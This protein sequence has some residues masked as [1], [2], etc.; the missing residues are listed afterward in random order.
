MTNSEFRV[1]VTA[2]ITALQA[3]LKGVQAELDKFK[4]SADG[5][6]DA[7][8]AVEANANRGRLVAFAFGQVLRD[9]GFF[10]QDFRLGILAISNNIPILIDQL[11]LLSG[12]SKAVGGALSLLGSLLTAGLTIWAYSGDAVKKNKQSI[13]DWRKSLDD[14]I[15][16]QLR[17]RQA[18][19]E[20]STSL[21]ILYRAATNAA[22]SNKTRTQAAK[23]LQN[24]YPQIFGNL[25]TEAIKLGK[26]KTAYDELKKSIIEAATAEAA[27]N[28][29]VENVSR[30]LDNEE[31][32]REAR[33]KRIKAEN[34][35][36]K[37]QQKTKGVNEDLFAA[38]MAQGVPGASV[39]VNNDISK[40]L[41]R[42]AQLKLEIAGYDKT[43]YS[44]TSDTNTLNERNNQLL[45]EIDK[46]AKSYVDSLSMGDLAPLEKSTE[47]VDER[48]KAIIEALNTYQSK[49]SDIQKTPAITPFDIKKQSVEALGDLIV[50]LEKIEGTQDTVAKLTQKFNELNLAITKFPFSL[51]LFEMVPQM[52]K[53]FTD[54][55][56]RE[57]ERFRQQVDESIVGAISN[58]LAGMGQAIANGTN[59]AKGALGGF[60]NAMS[61][62]LQQVGEGIIRTAI[63]TGKLAIFIGK[64][65]AGIQKAL[66]TMNP[67]LAIGAGVALLALA[68]AAR[69]G[70][71]NIARG[72]NADTGGGASSTPV[73]S[74]FGSV[75]GATAFP[76][77][78][79]SMAINSALSRNATLE[80][81]VS[82][83]DLV[84]LM[85]RATNNR[86]EYF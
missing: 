16:V 36:L 84:I 81:R 59:V 14:A 85:N 23:E 27:K 52:I 42:Q 19:L 9:A 60:L 8:K 50:S 47:V 61:G 86:N 17:G 49:L 33:I 62:I 56:M 65:I 10:A 13:D 28:K 18:A 77:S 73:G 55:S 40:S 48:M 82:G 44:A 58:S 21:D 41:A 67:L 43:I 37:E 3:S 2:D 12:V 80:T 74:S 24:L 39:K 15:E 66:A 34:E 69:G 35:L 45:Q 83:N 79:S 38:S 29:I 20:E 68:G 25:D 5:A 78:T 72:G 51:P 22:N 57:M 1:N 76:T 75:R 64:A 11:V 4:K 26:A 53:Q 70:A 30:Q 71:N 32:V 46:N 6:A 54:E 7:T 31:A 63:K